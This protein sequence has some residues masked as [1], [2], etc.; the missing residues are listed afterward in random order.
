[1]VGSGKAK[2][3]FQGLALQ[4]LRRGE[5]HGSERNSPERWTMTAEQNKA[6]SY[7]SWKN[8]E[9]AASASL[10]RFV[11]WISRFTRPILAQLA[12]RA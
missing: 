9:K 12:E 3:H 6:S 10:T 1:M 5:Q 4:E 11:L 8:C 7:D 2:P